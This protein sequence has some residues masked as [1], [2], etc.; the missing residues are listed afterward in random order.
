MHLAT[1]MDQQAFFDA[2]AVLP[3]VLF[4]QPQPEVITPHAPSM[5]AGY[6]GMPIVP[7]VSAS[8]APSPPAGG[9]ILK[10]S[11]GL[12]H[13]LPLHSFTQNTMHST[14]VLG[15]KPKPH[16][17]KRSG[18]G[19]DKEGA[20]G[21]QDP[22]PALGRSGGSADGVQGAQRSATNQSLE[23]CISDAGSARNDVVSPTAPGSTQRA[24][25]GTTVYI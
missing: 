20:T 13:G 23:G 10:A 21:F 12:S 24:T 11:Q 15:G 18:K 22:T 14:P 5:A 17:A 16:G 9:S 6:G 7:A 1:F 3:P 4:R 2:R 8:P 19:K 25:M